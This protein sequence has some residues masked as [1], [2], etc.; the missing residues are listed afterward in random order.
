M[1]R[2][3]IHFRGGSM[4]SLKCKNAKRAGEIAAKRP[5]TISYKFY[6]D[7]DVIPRLKKQKHI[8]KGLT[9]AEMER[10]IRNM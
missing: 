6:D 1:G 9:M 10:M 2:V 7:N 4:T 8:Q 3:I 5:N